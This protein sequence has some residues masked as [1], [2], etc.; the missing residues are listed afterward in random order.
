MAEQ[1]ATIRQLL[2]TQVAAFPE[3]EFL[4]SE[5]DGRI[6]TYRAFDEAVN[7]AANLLL[8]AGIEKGKRV[9]LFLTNSAEYLIFYFA[10][11]KIGAW[12]G[13]INAHLK[14][15]EIEFVVTNSEASVIVTQQDLLPKVEAVRDHLATVR[16]VLLIEDTRAQQESDSRLQTPDSRLSWDDEAVIIYTSGT[17]GKPKGVLLTHGNLLTN[18]REIAEWLQLTEGDRALLIMPLFHVN[19]LMTTTMAALWAGGSCVLAPGFSASR[20]WQRVSDYGVTYFGSV[21]TM[22]SLLIQ[23]YPQGIPE[24]CD[25]SRLRF[26]LCGSAPVPLEVAKQYEELFHCPVIEG[27]GLSESSCRATF[28]PIDGRRRLGSIGL[29]IGNEVKI[30]DEDD[31]EVAPGVVGEI[32]LRGANIMKG[33]YKNDEANQQAF[34][35]GWFHTGDLGYRDADGF[36]VIVDRKSDMIIR[37][38]ENI[39]PR[40]IDEVLYQHPKVKDA[41]TIGVPDALYGEGV[42]SFIVLREGENATEEEMIAYC[43]QHLA[44]FKCPKTIA[45]LE[46]IPKGPT[47]K[48]L[49]KRLRE[50]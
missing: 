45:F 31:K 22:L 34:R 16:E 11:F 27:Y 7:Q 8:A 33:Y 46:D 49:K 50:L 26:A 30:F 35:S 5:A 38:G 29:P 25:T 15:E 4:F 43:Q 36:F 1:F 41:A 42:K 12:A 13:P 17:T 14:A 21:A 24:G 10:C 32:V 18:A 28:N 23:T 39:Y 19:A 3:K 48:L 20:H 40:E 2:E 9:S 47:G 6:F 44:D 37:A